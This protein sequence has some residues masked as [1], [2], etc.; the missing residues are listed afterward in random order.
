[1]SASADWFWERVD[2]SGSG[3]W[4]WTRGKIGSGYGTFRIERNRPMLAHRRAWEL[5]RGGIPDGM[6]V[7]HHCDNR[8]CVRPDHLFLGTHL[9]NA[10]DR[11]SK[12]RNGRNGVPGEQHYAA[13][14]TDALVLELRRKWRNGE[15]ICEIAREHGLTQIHVSMIVHERIWKHLISDEESPA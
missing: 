7:L 6:F 8:T 13:R 4:N 1:M 9:E 11:A 2:R 10:R 5:T 12:G 14:L 3:C 15:R